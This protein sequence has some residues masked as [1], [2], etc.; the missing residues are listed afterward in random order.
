MNARDAYA[1]LRS[2]RV[3][4][5]ETGEAAALLR[6]TKSA[7]SRTLSRLALA[8][9]VTRV[10]SGTWWIDGEVQ[11]ERL[12]SFL[13][14]PYPGYVSL[15]T[16]LWLHGMVEQIPSITYVVSLSRSRRIRTSVGTYSIHH[17][18]PVLFGGFEGRHGAFVAT[19]EKALFD[20]AYLA[21][22]RGKLGAST[23]E[24]ELPRGFR[25]RELRRWV[26]KI[27]SLRAKALVEK[28]LAKILK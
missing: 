11:R 26:K 20:I 25:E 3:P 10:R 1:L 15:S 13:I 22:G 16:A 27:P 24:L 8:G 21:G 28:R 2:A 12:A 6:Q 14:A 9:L 4:A 18:D 7:A 17:I 19:P 5:I 23:P